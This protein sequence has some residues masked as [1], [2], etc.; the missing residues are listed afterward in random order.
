MFCL[1]EEQAAENKRCWRLYSMAAR[2]TCPTMVSE[3]AWHDDGKLSSFTYSARRRNS[4]LFIS[5]RI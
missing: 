1:P 2:Y 4:S 3:R 5:L